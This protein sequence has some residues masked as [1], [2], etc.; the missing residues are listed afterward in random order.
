MGQEIKKSNG[1][2]LVN[3]WNAKKNNI[4]GGDTNERPNSTSIASLSLRSKKN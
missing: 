1:Q 2:Y 4:F 3:K